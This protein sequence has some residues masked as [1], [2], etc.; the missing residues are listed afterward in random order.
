MPVV[1]GECGSLGLYTS[2]E[3]PQ[4]NRTA[5]GP[6]NP[7]LSIHIRDDS[8]NMEY[9]A[10]GNTSLQISVLGF[11]CGAVGGLM[12][13]GEHR[14]MLRSVDYALE[15]GINYFDTARMYG[16]GLSEI[17]IGAVLRELQAK[18]ALIGT[19]VRLSADEFDDIERTIEGQI[20]NSLRRL[21]RESVDIVYTHNSISLARNPQDGRLALDDLER[22]VGVFRG[23]VES[24]KIRHWGLNGLGDTEAVHAAVERFGPSAIHT[25][26]NM[27]NPTS[28]YA[29]PSGFPFQDYG[30]LMKMAA[31]R[32]VGT[33]AIR[34]LAAGALSGTAARHP[35]AAQSVAPIATGQTLEEDL[36][37]TD[38][39]DFLVT[40]GFSDSLVEAAIRFAISDENLSTALVGLS[41]FEQLEQAVAT[42]NK[43]PLVREAIDRLQDVWAAL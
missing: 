2:R 1:V 7:R 14:E 42:T 11:G 34:V 40:D 21:G 32:G 28:S 37:W 35:I 36:A 27:L 31:G 33:V 5:I 3:P 8:T 30:Q 43:G 13:R 16:D 9:R 38:A 24:G 6:G 20:D 15:S 25:C 10:F 26:H 17:H 29:T 41:S 12:V 22:I 19:K 23:A 4:Y 39:L 18:D